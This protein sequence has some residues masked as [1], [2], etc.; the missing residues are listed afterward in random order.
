MHDHTISLDEL[1]ADAAQ[2]LR[3]CEMLALS[4][5]VDIAR[6]RLGSAGVADAADELAHRCPAPDEQLELRV[7]P[8]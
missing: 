3:D 7:V 8:R 2:H 6:A 4:E 1:L 5:A